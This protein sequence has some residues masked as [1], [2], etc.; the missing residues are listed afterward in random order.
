[1]VQHQEKRLNTRSDGKLVTRIEDLSFGLIKA[2]MLNHSKT[3]SYIETNYP[4]QPGKEI[5]IGI[6]GS[7]S[8][9]FSGKYA[10]YRAR[11]IRKQKSLYSAFKYGYG[12]RY[13][14]WHDVQNTKHQRLMARKNLRKHPRNPFCLAILFL[15]NEQLVEGLIKDISRNGAFIET[16]ESFSGGQIVTLDILNKQKHNVKIMGKVVWHNPK[17]IGIQFLDVKK[18]M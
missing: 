4:L 14:F 17:G 6:E 15:S 2:V 11:I 9:S 13:I 10:C 8:K 7:P 5:C 12:I 3:G 18:N 16:Q 1:M